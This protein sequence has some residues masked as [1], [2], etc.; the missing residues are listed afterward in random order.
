MN[1]HR[2]LLL[3]ALGLGLLAVAGCSTIGDFLF[4]KGPPRTA[5]REITVST[6]IAANGGNA[7]MLDIV[8][9]YDSAAIARLPQTG[10][11]WFKQKRALQNALA[12]SIDVVALEIPAAAPDFQVSFPERASKA[13]GVYALANYLSADGQPIANLTPWRQATIRL[14]PTAIT[15][16]AQ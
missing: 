16:S 14:L 13:I 4:G 7:T 11:E 10:P 9:V 12:T 8:F 2:T 3:L 5:L 1:A 15:Y 6:D